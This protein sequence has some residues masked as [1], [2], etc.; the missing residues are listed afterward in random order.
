MVD[1]E[2]YEVGTQASLMTR[3]IQR[4]TDEL[5]GKG[6]A[7]VPP[8]DALGE[9]ES[10]TRSPAWRRVWFA[11]ADSG[12]PHMTSAVLAHVDRSSR[13]GAFLSGRA[14]IASP[15]VEEVLDACSYLDFDA[16]SFSGNMIDSIPFGYFDNRL[17]PNSSIG[18]AFESEVEYVANRYMKSVNGPVA[19]WFEQRGSI[20]GVLKSAMI[21]RAT[22][23][24]KINPE[25]MGL[26]GSI[27]LAVM[28]GR[29]DDAARVMD[30]Y[31]RRNSFHEW[32]SCAKA[33]AF[34]IALGRQ[35]G[36]YARARGK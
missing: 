30:W 9:T 19:E 33:K 20:D 17:D 15:V 8:L 13:G 18:L 16:G 14:Y 6:F 10:G 35:F 34:D 24:D 23:F 2:G 11:A 21:P 26:R 32:D 12:V 27:I 28:A 36:E 1:M 5:A 29:Y 4:L 25:P 7:P 31:I 22:Y 3:L